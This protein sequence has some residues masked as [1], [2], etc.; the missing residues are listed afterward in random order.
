[1]PSS[2]QETTSPSMMHER[3]R[4]FASVSTI[5]GKRGSDH[6]PDGCRAHPLATFAAI[7]RKPSHLI[8]CSQIAPEGGC[9]AFIGRH[10]A[11]K[12][13]GKARER[14][15]IANNASS[16]MAHT[17]V[18]KSGCTTTLRGRSTTLWLPLGTRS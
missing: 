7:T 2:S 5:S 1:M 10:G 11:M 4:S 3:K 8:S 9:G 13:A 6:C 18:S 14:N 15:D 16:R 17:K 12:P